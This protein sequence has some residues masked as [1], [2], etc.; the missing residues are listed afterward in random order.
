MLTFIS[1]ILLSF[2][3][4]FHRTAAFEWFVVI[5]I[6]FM[7]RSDSL[8]ITSIIR[9]LTLNPSL[10]SCL[11]HFF[12]AS[13]WE[14]DSV[15][16]AWVNIV[17]SKAPLRRIAGRTV[18]IGDGT[19]RAA[20]GKY[21]PCV[22]KMVQESESASKP[23]FIH[24]HF[25]GAVGVLVG[26]TIKSFCLPLSIQIHD[27]D[28]IISQWEGD[29]AVSHVVQMLRDGFRAAAHFGNSLLVLDRYFLTVPLL[30]EWKQESEEHPELLHVVTRAKKNCIA[31]EEPRA[32]AGDAARSMAGRSGSRNFLLRILHHLK[33]RFFPCMGQG[34]RFVIVLGFI[35]GAR[36]CTC[37]CS[38][39]L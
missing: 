30:N 29:E 32:K 27:G 23:A 12:R 34:S 8:G 6:G 37:R 4:C 18:L 26:N 31:Y 10:Y 35:C 20:D 13:S 21:M 2:S 7:V 24:G 33:K 17:A 11:E 15:F 3:S 28:Q 25:F 38:L 39:F 22:K 5:V 16:Y 1:K 9:D 36:G 14:W 19:K